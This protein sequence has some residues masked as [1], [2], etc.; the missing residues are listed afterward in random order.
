MSLSAPQHEQVSSPIT[1]V[2]ALEFDFEAYV[3]GTVFTPDGTPVFALGDGSLRIA[4]RAVP[5][6]IQVHRGAILSLAASPDGNLI[7]G[8]DDGA[9]VQMSM[10][11]GHEVVFRVDG[12]WIENITTSPDGSSL[13]CTAGRE[14]VLVAASGKRLPQPRRFLHATTASSI[15][16]D[17]K[18]KRLAVAHYG[19]V[20]LW[21]TSSDTQTPV[22]Y[23]WRGSHLKV[24]YSPD[25]RYLLTA[26]QENSL[27]GWRSADKAHFQ[28]SGF[29]ARIKSMSWGPKGRWLITSG[30]PQGLIWSFEGKQ[31]P[32]GRDAREIGHADA[33]IVCAVAAH[34][35]RDIAAMGHA[36]GSLVLGQA[37]GG[38]TAVLR[39]GDG[40]AISALAWSGDGER[41]AVGS[42]NGYGA[43][44]T[45]RREA[46]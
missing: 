32:I 31:G 17:P 10:D 38:E 33:P 19:G 7:T 21:W 42:E 6:A 4:D 41:L 16:F 30:A 36:D 8:G 20:S 45:F 39:F 27:H 35:S 9:L 29:P 14:A 15:C 25:G 40:A 37:I 34:P 43:V 1:A 3:T 23:P 28:M 22:L 18:G 5:R 26:M 46:L 11:G 2:P 12:C 44:L 13:A 24:S